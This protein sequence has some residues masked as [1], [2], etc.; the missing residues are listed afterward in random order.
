MKQTTKSLNGTSFHGDIISTTADKLIA[1]FGPPQYECNDGSDK[2]NMEW[3]M[4]DEFGDVFA[5]YDWKYYRPLRMDEVVPWHIGCHS[6]EISK[7]IVGRL[8]EIL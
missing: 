2:T 6:K 1:T 5:L 8:K 3:N 7:R 4:E